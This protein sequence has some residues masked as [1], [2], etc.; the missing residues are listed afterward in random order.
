MYIVLQ[1]FFIFSQKIF[2]ASDMQAKKVPGTKCTGDIYRG[3]V[4]LNAKNQSVYS[5]AAFKSDVLPVFTSNLLS[6]SLFSTIT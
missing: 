1:T 3:K 2:D 6:R 4:K 5:A